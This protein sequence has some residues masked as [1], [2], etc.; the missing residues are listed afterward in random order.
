[1]N[2]KELAQLYSNYCAIYGDLMLKKEQLDKELQV[3]RSK[4]N[5]LQ[6]TN[7]ENNNEQTTSTPKNS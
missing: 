2:N 6:S 1:M 4:I 7:T 5:N 3:I